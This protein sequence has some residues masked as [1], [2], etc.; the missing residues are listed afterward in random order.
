M[1]GYKRVAV[2]EKYGTQDISNPLAVTTAFARAWALAAVYIH[3]TAAMTET[4]TV[5]LDSSHAANYDCIFKTEA[6]TG[7][8]SASYVPDTPLPL[9]SGDE[10]LVSLTSAT[11][12]G[13]LGYQIIGFELGG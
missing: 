9:L 7:A 4:F 13:T 8:T 10:I 11:A 5:T 3:N 1:G 12:T 6:L 2:I